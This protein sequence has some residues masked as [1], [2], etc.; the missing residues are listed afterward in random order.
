MYFPS[1]SEYCEFLA[2]FYLGSQSKNVD[3]SGNL[4]DHLRGWLWEN[5]NIRKHVFYK[6]TCK[7]KDLSGFYWYY[8]GTLMCLSWE[9]NWDF[10]KEKAG[11]C[12]MLLLA[13][14]SLTVTTKRGLSILVPL[15]NPGLGNLN[16]VW[17]QNRDKSVRVRSQKIEWKEEVVMI[18]GLK[19]NRGW[20]IFSSNLNNQLLQVKMRN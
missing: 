12:G 1:A 17:E 7:H 10:K 9:K 15:R 2:S 20:S 18:L 6:I 5:K 14:F 19:E 4:K 11:I 3:C 8:G 13:M 16:Q